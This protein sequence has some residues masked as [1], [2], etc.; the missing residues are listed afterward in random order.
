MYREF[1][2]SL[3]GLGDQERLPLN[4]VIENMPFD[5]SGLLPVITQDAESKDVLMF[6][7]MNRESLEV[8]LATGRM[9]YWSRSRNK[10]WAKG[11]SSGHTQTLISMA[12]DC[13]GDAILCNVVQ[14]GPACHTGR[15]DCFYLQV[16]LENQQ[17]VIKGDRPKT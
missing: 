8:T 12:F 1:F 2:H 6:A 15:P 3:E 11:E 13:D 4:E 17:V 5:G 16:D 7:W 10:L 14:A 9:T